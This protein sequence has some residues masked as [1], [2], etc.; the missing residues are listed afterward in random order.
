MV[1]SGKTRDLGNGVTLTVGEGTMVTGD[2]FTA[3]TYKVSHDTERNRHERRR[4]AALRRRQGEPPAIRLR[5][6][7]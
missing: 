1:D 6:S 7:M 3:V 2:T 5:L 4:A